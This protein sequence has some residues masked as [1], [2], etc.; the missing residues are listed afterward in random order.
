MRNPCNDVYFSFFGE[1][2]EVATMRPPNGLGP[3]NPTEK[4]A[5]WVDLLGQPLSRNHSF[6]ILR[7]EPPSPPLLDDGSRYSYGWPE[8]PP[9][10]KPG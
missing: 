9:T 8:T 3:P 7:P 5:H 6:E 4:L 10:P 2:M 1:K